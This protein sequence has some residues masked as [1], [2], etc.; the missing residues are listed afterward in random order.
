MDPPPCPATVGAAAAGM[1]GPFAGAVLPDIMQAMAKGNPDAIR[2]A[3]K[4]F[5]SPEFQVLLTEAATQPKVA[6]RAI[7]RVASSGRFRDFA[8]TIGLNMKDAKTWL[9]AAAAPA[10]VTQSQQETMAEGAPI[11]RIQ[12]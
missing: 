4:M 2:A 10:A 8:K 7:N 5:S 6:D 3:G 1:G 12:Q 9:K 11:V